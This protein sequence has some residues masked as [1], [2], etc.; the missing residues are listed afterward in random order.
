MYHVEHMQQTSNSIIKQ[1]F[2]SDNSSVEGSDN[3]I[4]KDHDYKLVLKEDEQQQQQHSQ[5][6]VSGVAKGSNNI[7]ME[8][9]PLINSLKESNFINT[10]PNQQEQS[11]D[12]FCFYDETKG[13]IAF[14]SKCALALINVKCRIEDVFFQK[15]FI[16]DLYEQS[17]TYMDTLSLSGNAE[18]IIEEKEVEYDDSPFMP[19]TTNVRSPS[20]RKLSTSM[21]MRK[22]FVTVSP[23]KHN[24]LSVNNSS[25]NN[26]KV[27]VNNNNNNRFPFEVFVPF[28]DTT[29]IKDVNDVTPNQNTNA[30]VL[31]RKALSIIRSVGQGNMLVRLESLPKNSLK[32]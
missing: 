23:I 2:N 13:F 17:L 20:G 3:E 29:S 9:S 4:K 25:N 24:M 5:Y 11:D 14:I 16:N 21:R 7:N 26:N 15:T 18:D 12:S 6:Q 31:M 28:N 1:G 10:I 30:S 22:S 8:Y 32:K 19:I 27:V